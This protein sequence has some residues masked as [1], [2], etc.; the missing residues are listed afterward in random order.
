MIL[1]KSSSCSDNQD[2]GHVHIFVVLTKFL[3][4]I[5]QP[6]CLSRYIMGRVA[7]SNV[8]IL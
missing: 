5:A 6:S 2:G 7:L 8:D 4:M 1:K 3:F